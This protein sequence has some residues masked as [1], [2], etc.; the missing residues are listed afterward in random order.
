VPVLSRV[1]A[2]RVRGEIAAR[3]FS[4]IHPSAAGRPNTCRLA[5]DPDTPADLRLFVWVQQVDL[6]NPQFPSEKARAFGGLVIR[7]RNGVDLS[8][9]R[10][11]LTTET[12][13]PS[14]TFFRLGKP[15]EAAAREAADAFGAWLI[16]SPGRMSAALE[17][18]VADMRGR[19]PDAE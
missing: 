5:D 15:W 12:A 10:N 1:A 4:A 19:K 17:K 6:P 18:A 7:S 14:N 11:V 13:A 9:S 16:G 3:G 2:E 8:S